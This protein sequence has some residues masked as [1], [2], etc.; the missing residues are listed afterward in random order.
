MRKLGESLA[1]ALERPVAFAGVESADALLSNGSRGWSL[2]G[3][4]RVDVARL[5]DWTA[6]WLARG[7]ATSGKP[8]HFE[9]GRA[10]SDGGLRP[11]LQCVTGQRP[12][13]AQ[14]FRPAELPLEDMT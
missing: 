1:V 14:A 9:S 3:A 10:D 11:A 12:H 8:T 13:V 5:V 6:D 2:L 4:P 7:R